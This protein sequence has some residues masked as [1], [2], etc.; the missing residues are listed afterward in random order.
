MQ[1]LF[2]AFVWMLMSA[3]SFALALMATPFYSTY[4]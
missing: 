2:V 4:L 3:F 1:H